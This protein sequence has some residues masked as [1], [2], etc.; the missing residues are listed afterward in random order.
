MPRAAVLS[1][2]A[3][4]ENCQTASWEDPS[5]L[6]LW[7]PRYNVYTVPK[8]DLAVFSLGRLSTN[9][10]A[11]SR[12]ERTGRSLRSLLEGRTMPFGEAGRLLGVHPNSLRYAAPTGTVLLRWDGARQPT[13]W[14]VDPP[15]VSHLQ[16]RLELARRY[17]HL[18]GPTTA[19][20]FA[21]WA[22]V[23]DS[24]ALDV[25][26]EL[27]KELKA[28]RTPVGDRWL[29][30]SD[31]TLLFSRE[32][33]PGTTRLLPSG[34]NYFLAWDEDRILL[35]PNSTHR[36]ALWTSRVWPGALLFRGEIVGTWRRSAHTVA[37][38]TWKLLT[39]SERE[40]VEVEVSSLP[41]GATGRSIATRWN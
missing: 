7:G 10:E 4:I 19:L 31:E 38:T 21:R 16:A 25:F 18:F 35:V 40:L 3:R 41:V 33:L 37:I 12:A 28:V 32:G 5:L 36:A 23:T 26:R 11:R 15:Q 13:I 17:L 24:E 29:L 9:P 22:A 8:D 34:D 30:A 6:Q 20:S 1:L 2:H 14:C 39:R 27:G